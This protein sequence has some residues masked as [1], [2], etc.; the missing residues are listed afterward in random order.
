MNPNQD[1]ASVA[2][3]F[4]WIDDEN[5]KFINREGLSVIFNIKTFEVSAFN[6]DPLFDIKACA[7]NHYWCSE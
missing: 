4:I 7:R 5:A 3:R 2:H 1:H 6:V